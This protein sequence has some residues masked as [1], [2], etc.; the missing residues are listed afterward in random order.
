MKKVCLKFFQDDATGEYGLAHSN[1]LDKGF[2]AFWNGIGIFHDVF[3]HA[4]E[5]NHKYFRG[6]YAFNVG[7]EMMASGATLY[8]SEEL[9]VYNRRMRNMWKPW[10]QNVIESGYGV[11]IDGLAGHGAYSEFGNEL[12]SKVPYQRPV[13][14]SSLEWAI[15]DGW[16]TIQ[17]YMNRPLSTSDENEI[18]EIRDLRK[19]VTKRKFYDLYRYGFRY[20]ERMVPDNASNRDTLIE[21]IDYWNAVTKNDTAEDVQRDV[22]SITFSLSKNKGIISWQAYVRLNIGHTFRLNKNI[23]SLTEQVLDYYIDNNIE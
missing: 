7:G 10:E 17:G 15:T 9:G 23:T 21:F 20:A 16:D 6:A 11:I 5:D 1:A 13:Y 22:Y 4:H 12:L 3:E 8:Y 18:E 2:N 14:S 19:S